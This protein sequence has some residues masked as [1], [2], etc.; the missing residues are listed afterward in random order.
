MTLES[1]G[2]ESSRPTEAEQSFKRTHQEVAESSERPATWVGIGKHFLIKLKVS[3]EDKMQQ[4]QQW[5]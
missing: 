3:H 2:Q 5:E 1:L 4:Q